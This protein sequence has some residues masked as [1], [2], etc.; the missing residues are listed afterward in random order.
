[1]YAKSIFPII[2][3]NIVQSPSP[4]IEFSNFHSIWVAHKIRKWELNKIDE[5]KTINSGSVLSVHP[6]FQ[7][8]PT[9]YQNNCASFCIQYECY[10]EDWY[11][12]LKNEVYTRAAMEAP[13]QPDLSGCAS[14]WNSAE[15][16]FICGS[17]PLVG[18]A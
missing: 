7:T 15:L 1:M 8:Q 6:H 13:F 12:K 18:W 10:Q 16:G 5:I 4:F 3:M 14:R 2:S 17:S 11:R 9:F